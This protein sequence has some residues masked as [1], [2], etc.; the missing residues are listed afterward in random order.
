[1]IMTIEIY[2]KE[3]PHIFEITKNSKNI[4]EC[5]MLAHDGDFVLSI[6]YKNGIY[7]YKTQDLCSDKYNIQES[8]ESLEFL[9]W[10]CE[11][12]FHSIFRYSKEAGINILINNLRRKY[13]K[14]YKN[15]IT[16]NFI[17]SNIFI[18]LNGDT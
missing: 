14:S 8:Y 11:H 9:I 7:I 5:Y 10:D 3:I 12:I 13:N 4:L 18:P 17:I 15:K 2:T 6:E 16:G 1:M